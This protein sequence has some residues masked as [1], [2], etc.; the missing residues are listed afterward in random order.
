MDIS[1]PGYE[2]KE[3]GKD[4]WFSRRNVLRAA[5]AT[6]TGI[7]FGGDLEIEAGRVIS[8]CP[9]PE[10]AREEPEDS[11]TVTIIPDSQNYVEGQDGFL[12]DFMDDELSYFKAQRD[13]ILDNQEDWNIR[14]VT[15][16]G[17]VV[18]DPD[19][20]HQWSQVE[21]ILEPIPD[22]IPFNV[23]PGNHDREKTGD[24]YS[25]ENFR[26]H[27]GPDEFQEYD[28]FESRGADGMVYRQEFSGGG[29]E[30]QNIGLPHEP[31]ESQLAAAGEA[32][33]EE[34]IPTIVTTHGYLRDNH[35]YSGRTR[36]TVLKDGNSGVQINDKLVKENEE[37][38]AVLGGHSFR[39]KAKN[40]DGGEYVQVSGDGQDTLIELLANFQGR[41]NGGNGYLKLMEF[42]RGVE[43]CEEYPDSIHIRTYSPENGWELDYDS[44]IRIDVDLDIMF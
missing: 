23:S 28:W 3:S 22:K 16:V 2:K 32:I 34:G 10:R 38:F 43:H 7:S 5:G 30:F 27:F 9:S 35:D 26:K 31:T 25:L 37:V 41:P 18:D 20:E 36:E 17:D 13:W 11:F 1:E 44:D 21:E 29:Q 15:H 8:G 19:S 4:P 14:F 40:D 24:G 12:E 42:R 6:L 33:R 39:N